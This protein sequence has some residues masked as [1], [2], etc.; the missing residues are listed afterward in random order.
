MAT[1]LK[2]KKPTT[3]ET[4]KKEY[5]YVCEFKWE[6][7]GERKDSFD[8]DEAKKMREGPPT[9]RTDHLLFMIYWEDDFNCWQRV[10]VL[11]CLNTTS[12]QEAADWMLKGITTKGSDVPEHGPEYFKNGTLEVIK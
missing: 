6:S 3:N 12:H 5:Y 11:A 7:Y 8:F 9:I 1:F 2:N 10:H 4:I